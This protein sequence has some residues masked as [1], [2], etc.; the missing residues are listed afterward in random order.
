MRTTLAISGLREINAIAFIVRLWVKKEGEWVEIVAM[1]AR[2][3]T[4]L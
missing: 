1:S 3:A 4:A 2:S